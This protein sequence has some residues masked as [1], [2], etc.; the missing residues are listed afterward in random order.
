[1][2]DLLTRS[3]PGRRKAPHYVADLVFVLSSSFLDHPLI[4]LRD[5]LP[6]IREKSTQAVALP[7][8]WCTFHF[9]SLWAD[10]V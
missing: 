6:V 1:M 3:G 7:V 10:G 9:F 5:H 2:P 4:E 8:V